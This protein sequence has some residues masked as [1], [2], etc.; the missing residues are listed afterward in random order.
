MKQTIRPGQVK[1]RQA[2][3]PS[4]P[5]KAGMAGT[6]FGLPISEPLQHL[7][8]RYPYAARL[9]EHHVQ[10]FHAANKGRTYPKGTYLFEEGQD[11]RGV[12][13]VLDGRVKL[14]VS[15]SN[16]KGMVL[17]FFGAG[18][19]LGMAAAILGRKHISTAE[20]ITPTTAV[21]VSRRQFAAEMQS[22]PL[23][24]WPVAQMIAEHCFFW[25]TKMA[26]VE[27]S[28]SAQQKMARCLLGIMHPNLHDGDPVAL[29]VSQ[30]TIAQ[31]V[32]LSRETVSRQ[33]SRL[34][35]NGVLDWTRSN[36]I[37]RNRR[38][39]ERMADLPDIAEAPDTE[40]VSAGAETRRE[41]AGLD[42]VKPRLRRKAKP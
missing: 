31:I 23:A 20:T 7:S 26:T 35:R 21:F 22:H 14:S 12:Y 39:L 33:L 29:N 13:V 9:N 10:R 2:E 8:G 3:A 36:F 15:S 41:D 11:S 32:G 34:R 37:I 40:A 16:G 25:A 27:L 38:A 4:D 5:A 6:L 42:D 28:E 1:D 18:T 17:G 30:E 19:L 24:A